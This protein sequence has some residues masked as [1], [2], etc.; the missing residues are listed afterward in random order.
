MS[1]QNQFHVPPVPP[2]APSFSAPQAPVKKTPTTRKIVSVIKD[3]P[4]DN[5]AKAIILGGAILVGILLGGVFFGGGSTPP[6]VVQ[7][8]QGLVPNSSI[9][10]N[11]GRCGMVAETAPCIV[12]IVN[13]SRND[14]YAESFFDEAAR[15]TG[16]QPHRVR[17]ENQ[18]YAKTPIR[19]GY[20]A[21][22]KI[23]AR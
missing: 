9:R 12:Y 7:G 2:K 19:S 22:I 3:H 8:L 16:R 14:K 18:Q 17:I 5:L 13:H 6:P 23:P 11:L 1:D 10:E 20:I 15:L 4:E 21:Q